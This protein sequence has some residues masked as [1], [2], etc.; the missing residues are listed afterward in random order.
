MYDDWFNP[1][2]SGGHIL[3]YGFMNC[4]VHAVM[5]TYYFLSTYDR[6]SLARSKWMT[7]KNVTKLQLVYVESQSQSNISKVMLSTFNR[8]NSYWS[9]CTWVFPQCSVTA[10]TRRS[11]PNLVCSSVSWCL[12]CSQISTSAP[13]SKRRNHKRWRSMSFDVYVY[14]YFVFNKL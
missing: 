11:W 2:G 7:K 3:F 1:Y 4:M 13:T 10:I 12:C 5:Y 14:V 9:A 6:E 8:S